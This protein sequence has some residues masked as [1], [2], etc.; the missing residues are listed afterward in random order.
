MHILF[1]NCLSPDYVAEIRTNCFYVL[2][3]RFGSLW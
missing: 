1:V 3:H 2:S